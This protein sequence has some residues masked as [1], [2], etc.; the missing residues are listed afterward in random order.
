MAD[1]A[2]PNVPTRRYGICLHC[3]ASDPEPH[4]RKHWTLGWVV[5]CDR[6]GVLLNIACQ[7]CRSGLIMPLLKNTGRFNIGYCP[8]GCPLTGQTIYPA[9]PLA[10]RLQSSLITGRESEAVEWPSVGRISWATAIALIDFI[11]M[12]AWTSA[13]LDVRRRRFEPI[14]RE[15]GCNKPLNGSSHDGLLIA[16]WVLEQW[17]ARAQRLSLELTARPLEQRLA[18]R[19]GLDPGVREDLAALFCSRNGLR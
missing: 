9:H 15:L 11:L 18:H 7:H 6:H 8:R 14:E 2:L 5:G 12:I 1:A 17:P 19:K 16:S 3:L 13:D 10:I 4:L